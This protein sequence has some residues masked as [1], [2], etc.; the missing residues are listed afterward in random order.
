MSNVQ[1]W[2]RDFQRGKAARMAGELKRSTAS[3]AWRY[4]WNQQDAIMREKPKAVVAPLPRQDVHLVK[5]RMMGSG[6]FVR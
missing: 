2:R 5:R 3:D 6:R 1:E 4:G